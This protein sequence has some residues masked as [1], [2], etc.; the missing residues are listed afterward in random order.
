MKRFINLLSVVLLFILA[1]CS[2]D[3]DLFADYKDVPVV[4][5][6]ID[7]QADTNFIKI[8]KAFCNDDDNF[9]NPYAMALVYDSSNY[10]GKLEA[11]ITEMKSTH[12][13][14]YQPTGRVLPLDTITIHNKKAGLFYAPHQLLYYTTERFNTN[15]NG[16]KYR[17]KLF[18]VKPEG[19]TITSETGV[20]DGN[21]SIGTAKMKFQSEP[22]PRTSPL[23]FTATEEAAL[24]E[25]GMQFNYREAR[26]GQPEV[27]K[28]VTWSYGMKPIGAYEHVVGNCYQLFYSVNAL[29]TALGNA[30]GNDT[31]WDANHPEVIRYIDDFYIVIS[32]AGEDFYNYYQF[33]QSQQS[34]SLSNEYSN[35]EGGYG[36]FSSH[37]L[38]RHKVLLSSKTLYDLFDNT[39]WGFRER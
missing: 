4:Y 13:Q 27:K 22:S 6:L 23:L 25:I 2:T 37:I 28:E 15:A 12:D 8:T 29:F 35:V 24:Y 34:L 16:N 3:V 7:V 9:V 11:F 21:V 38:V 1:S 26:P 36:L 5:G 19:D 18:V 32:A 14:L 10:P 33:V 30:I 31:V 39:G 17:Y 20:V